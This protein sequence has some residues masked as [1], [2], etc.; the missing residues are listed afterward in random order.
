MVETAELSIFTCLVESARTENRKETER[1]REKEKEGGKEGKSQDSRQWRER[2]RGGG[3]EMTE[4]NAPP[5]TAVLHF[6]TDRHK[7]EELKSNKS[8]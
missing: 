7:I 1:E 8:L 3:E 5:L 4:T 6:L 2:E